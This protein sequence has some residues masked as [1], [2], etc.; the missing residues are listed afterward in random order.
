MRGP[1]RPCTFL[2]YVNPLWLDPLRTL[3]S[4]RDGLPEKHARRADSVARAARSSSS[5][6]LEQLMRT[7]ARR[8]V[9]DAM[10]WTIARQLDRKRP[11]GLTSSIRCRIMPTGGG[12]PDIYHLNLRD[13]RC[14]VERGAGGPRPGLT[15][16]VDDTELIR[17]A[18]GQSNAVQA[19]FNGRITVGGNLTGVAASLASMFLTPPR[20]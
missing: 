5:E 3:T 13:G 12:E 2:V 6:W 16:T 18:T 4:I 17:L 1:P 7:P 10:V 20:D 9:L 11:T 15:I 14:Q 19:L 8:F